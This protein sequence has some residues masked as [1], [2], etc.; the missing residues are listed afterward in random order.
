MYRFAEPPHCFTSVR[1]DDQ[2]KLTR[3]VILPVDEV[4][5]KWNRDVVAYVLKKFVSSQE[6]GGEV[7]AA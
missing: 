3:L 7:T 2:G 1:I 6:K 4:G 5:R